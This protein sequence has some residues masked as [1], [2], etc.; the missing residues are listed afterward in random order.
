LRFATNAGASDGGHKS[1]EMDEQRQLCADIDGLLPCVTE[2]SSRRSPPLCSS[3]S[4]AA[5]MIDAELV[6]RC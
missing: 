2:Q 3:W 5:I 4:E 6:A 1:V